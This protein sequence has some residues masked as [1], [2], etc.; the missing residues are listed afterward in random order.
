M[1]N[2]NL[3]PSMSVVVVL[4]LVITLAVAIYGA[5]IR[6]D[7]AEA[8]DVQQWEFLRVEPGSLDGCKLILNE[9]QRISDPNKTRY[10]CLDDLGAQGWELV[11]VVS[12]SYYF[13]RPR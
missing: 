11:T 4:L 9:S 1:R 7:G 8:R 6:S 10:D 13:K 2:T 5:F 12:T 3:N